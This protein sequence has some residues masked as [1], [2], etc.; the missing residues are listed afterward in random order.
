[1]RLTVLGCSGSLPGPAS[2]ASGY[3]VQT[4]GTRLVMDL[5][6]GT[7]GALQRHVGL[8]TLDQIDGVLIS[9]LHPDHY[10]DLCGYYVALRY[11]LRS[12]HRRVPVWGPPGTAERLAEAYGE[13]A[14]ADPIMSAEF[15]FRDY[16][17]DAFTIG[18][19]R[20]RITRV[21]HPVPTYAIRV[22]HAGRAL[23]YSADTGPCAALVELARGADALL[24]EAAFEG[25]PDPPPDLHLTGRQAGEHATAAGVGRLIVTH[26]PPWSNADDA[27]VAARQVFDGPV[28]AAAMDTSWEI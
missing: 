1:M 13:R 23:V 15:D 18:D 20:V 9:H 22:E 6:N 14:E 3:L 17:D 11:G 25:H 10:M 2:P 4:P 5:G 12:D 16:P 8:Q 19:V 28:E 21:V 27:A 26:V 7:L 24:C